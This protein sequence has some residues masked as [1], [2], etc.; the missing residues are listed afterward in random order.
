VKLFGFLA[1]LL[2]AASVAVAGARPTPVLDGF[3]I[4]LTL[5]HGWHGLAAPGQLQ[6]ADFRLGA[7]ALGS[8]ELARVPRGHVHLIV[9]DY[10]PAVPYLAANFRPA[11]PPL[12][13]G[14]RNLSSGPLEGFPDGDSYAVRTVT[15]GEELVELVADLGP[16]PFSETALQRVNRVLT[17]LRVQPP[18]VVRPRQGRLASGGVA[19]TLLPGWSGRIEIPADRQAAQ[20]VVRVRRSDVRIV[21]LELSDVGGG[22]ADLPIGLTTKNILRGH[23]SRIARRVFSSAGRGFD[24]SVVFSSPRQLALANR[25]LKT[26]T[27]VPLPWTFRSCELSIRLP[28][29]WRAAINPRS[30]CYPVIT[31][32]A[33][34]IRVVVTELRPHER[35][36]G[37]VLLRADRRFRVEVTPRSAT[38]EANAILATLQATP[39][40]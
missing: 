12:A 27:A 11:R 19:L 7:R 24:L 21:L 35:T 20:L 38:H 22:H 28:G 9:W 34:G 16:K 31:L 2:V 37:R 6:A 18:R 4:S 39:R 17:T 36:S 8:P 14:R 26:L 32:R 30:G 33:P 25:L 13:L 1:L 3:G 5:P 10:G 23:G 15:L 29:T 40:S